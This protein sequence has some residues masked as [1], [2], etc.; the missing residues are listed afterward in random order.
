MLMWTGGE[1]GLGAYVDPVATIPTRND[2]GLEHL[3]VVPADEAKVL[4]G[5]RTLPIFA[6]TGHTIFVSQLEYPFDH[7]KRLL[8]PSSELS[9]LARV[10]PVVRKD[11]FSV[12]LP[13]IYQT[14]STRD[15]DAIAA[16]QPS[17]SV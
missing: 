7:L 12:I 15:A 8:Y 13:V 16:N 3:R 2:S 1:S 6:Y 9:C 11:K 5:T 14:A 4:T 10:P 17:L